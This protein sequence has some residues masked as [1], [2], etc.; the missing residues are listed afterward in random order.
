MNLGLDYTDKIANAL[1][2]S[3]DKGPVDPLVNAERS[4][5]NVAVDKAVISN[6][7]SN[8]PT[9]ITIQDREYMEGKIKDTIAAS[10]SIREKLEKDIKENTISPNMMLRAY[11]VHSTIVNAIAIQIRELRELN[12]ML[13]SLEVINNTNI[14]KQQEEELKK[15]EEEE[16]KT[17]KMSPSEFLKQLIAEAEKEKDKKPVTDAEFVEVA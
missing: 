1:N 10:E 12:K 16:K 2:T 13:M 11:E 14:S 17:V 3:F 9:A 5:T 7:I 6:Q 8:L 15:K 4:L